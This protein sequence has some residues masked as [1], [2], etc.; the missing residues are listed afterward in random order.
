MLGTG[1]VHLKLNGGLFDDIYERNT[2]ANV[3]AVLRGH[4]QLNVLLH[5]KEQAPL[6]VLPQVNPAEIARQA[7]D[8]RQNYAKGPRALIH[9]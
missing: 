5:G 3:M 2:L 1:R 8:C 7:E 4:P 9:R 6:S